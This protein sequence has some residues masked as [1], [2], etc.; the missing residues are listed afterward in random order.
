MKE[1]SYF[2]SKETDPYENIALEEYLLHQVRE[3]EII[4][5]LWQNRRTVVIGYNQNPWRECQVEALKEDGGYLA[6]RLSGGGA[7]FHDTGNVN[8]TFLVRKKHYN[9]ERQSEVIVKAVQ[10]FG[11]PAIC[12]GRNDLTAEGRKFSGHAFYQNGDFCCHHGTIL[13]HTDKEA[14]SRYLN[15]SQEKLR[16]KGVESVR[17]RVVNLEEYIPGITVGQIQQAL[18]AALEAVYGVAEG[19]KAEPLAETRLDPEQIQAGRERFASWEWLYG[20]KI[21]FQYEK[22]HR[23]YWGEVVVQI[24]VSGGKIDQIAVWSDGLD[25]AFPWMLERV[26]NGC[27]Y[28]RQDMAERIAAADWSQCSPVESVEEYAFEY[29]QWAMDIVDL[30]FA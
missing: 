27:R 7:V 13:L 21:P 10:S 22:E 15:V 8:F 26:L 23:F 28:Q 16:S 17:S 18:I 6:R 2:V 29:Q 9:R 24:A 30:L 25:V 20:R 19:K 12:N 3:Q 14:M 5:Y 4:L 1:L 11:I